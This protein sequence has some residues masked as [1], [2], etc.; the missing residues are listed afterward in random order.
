[1]RWPDT[2][3]EALKSNDIHLR[4]RQRLAGRNAAATPS[5]SGAQPLHE[6]GRVLEA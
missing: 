3:V 2:S 4:P 1:M 5:G 6:G